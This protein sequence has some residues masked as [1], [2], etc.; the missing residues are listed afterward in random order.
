MASTAPRPWSFRQRFSWRPSTVLL[1]YVL[2]FAAVGALQPWL[3]RLLQSA[4]AWTQE[5]LGAGALMVWFPA[6]ILA[7]AF[8][9]GSLL[10]RN[11]QLQFVLEVLIAIGIVLLTPTY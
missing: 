6:A 10:K 5:T 2:A 9:I 7:L 1:A 8:F 4:V 3:P 11:P